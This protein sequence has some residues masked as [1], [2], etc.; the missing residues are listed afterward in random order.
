MDTFVYVFLQ[1]SKISI[2]HLIHLLVNERTALLSNFPYWYKSFHVSSDLVMRQ[3]LTVTQDSDQDT[4]LA[5]DATI[6]ISCKEHLLL[7][8]SAYQALFHL[9]GRTTPNL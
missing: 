5:S 9:C 8:I 2:V 6:G 4:T 1:N 3:C 7:S